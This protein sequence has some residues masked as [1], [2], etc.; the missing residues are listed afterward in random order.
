MSSNLPKNIEQ[1]LQATAKG[2]DRVEHFR[3]Y[4]KLLDAAYRTTDKLGTELRKQERNYNKM[5]D[6]QAFFTRHRSKVDVLIKAMRDTYVNST[7]AMRTLEDLALNY[8]TQYVFDVCQLGSYRL[9]GVQGWSFLNLR[10]ASRL[11]ADQNYVNAVLPAIAATLPDH[12]DYIELRNA[13]IEDRL[14]AE[15]DKLNEMRKAKAEIDTTLPKWTDAMTA[16]ANEMRPEDVARLNSQEQAVHEKLA[17]GAGFRLA[18]S[19]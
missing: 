18:N 1:L 13:G 4:V 3:A 5:K 8:P 14:Q 15:L 2:S 17:S 19:A 11:D 12:R 9:G 6:D 10:S 7:K 16:L